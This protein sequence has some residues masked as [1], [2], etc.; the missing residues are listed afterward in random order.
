MCDL[1]LNKNKKAHDEPAP[2]QPEVCGRGPRKKLWE[3]E[4]DFHCSIIGTCLKLNELRKLLRKCKIQV[5]KQ[6][7]DYEIHSVF[8]SLAGEKTRVTKNLQKMLDRK[9]RA[10]VDR[11]AKVTS[12]DELEALWNVSVE[13]GD[14]S[15]PYW[16]VMSHP[17]RNKTLTSKVYGEVHMLSH[18]VGSSNRADIRRLNEL[19]RRC[20]HR[21]SHYAKI[22]SLMK[23]RLNEQEGRIRSLEKS[24]A[25]A[26][27]KAGK[28]EEAELRLKT[29][30]SDEGHVRLTER[31]DEATDRAETEKQRA[32][33]AEQ[34]VEW[35]TRKLQDVVDQNER[36]TE[37]LDRYRQEC[38]VLEEELGN[39]LAPSIPGDCDQCDNRDEC[40][41][42]KLQGRKILYVGGRS[43]LVPHYR[44]LVEQHGGE[45]I[46]HDGGVEKAMNCL[47]NKLAGAD[48]VLCPV[49]CVSHAACLRIKQFCKALSR[50]FVMMRSSG[51]STFARELNAIAR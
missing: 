44:A 25:S 16:A 5:P 1:L 41:C 42:S 29:L 9:Y 26:E 18:L 38:L 47:N 35:L 49:D 20:H 15:G 8:V 32:E 21:E 31:L 17:A 7:R 11:Y 10:S 48:V 51:L 46:H 45:F 43:N 14:I 28:L 22:R 39:M 33:T 40:D 36:L 3:V 24:L 30:E 13:Q 23:E 12:P 2:P 4:S 27:E 6:A 19:D 37:D 34:Q 50:P